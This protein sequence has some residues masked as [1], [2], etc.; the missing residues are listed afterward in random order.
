MQTD[1]EKA[2][3]DYFD[4]SMEYKALYLKEALKAEAESLLRDFGGPF[5]SDK[6]YE[7]IIVPFWEKYGRI[8]EKLW[9][10]VF[11]ERD[12]IVEPRIIPIDFYFN[13]LL[14]YLNNLKLRFATADKCTYDVRL[15]EIKQPETVCKCTAGL[16][17]DADMN[18]ISRKEAIKACLCNEGQ[19]VMKPSI[20]SSSS[21]NVHA[22]DPALSS[23]KDMEALFD[24]LG[25]YFIVQRR[26]EQHSDL[27]KLNPDTVN[28]I[29]VNSVLSE[30]GVYIPHMLI[31]V[32]GPDQKIVEQGSGGWSSEIKKDG[33]LH[34][35]M[36]INNVRFYKNE[37]GE[38]CVSNT[39]KWQQTPEFARPEIGYRIPAV[40]KLRSAV[41]E[42][43]KKLPHFRWIGWDFTIDDTGDPVL[44]EYNL[45][46]GYHGGQLTVCKPMFG[47]M[48]EEILDDYFFRRSLENNHPGRL[49]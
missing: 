47:D 29:R 16:Y 22:V 18:M 17:Y 23:E 20:N 40:D 44:I 8:P 43:H 48:T 34:D 42:A 15:R 27:A 4:K 28:T 24:R 32:G 30:D 7:D 33:S 5:I 45:A 41:C 35:K 14:P 2:Y 9:F 1:Y 13:E 31:R 36:I 26:I 37:N 10:D 11:G 39:M 38:E 19:M 25:A 49:L 46:P 21:R 6:E 12:R 3:K